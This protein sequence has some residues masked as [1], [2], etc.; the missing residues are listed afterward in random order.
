[1][2]IKNYFAQDA[3]GNIMP[4]AKC[5]LYLPGTTTLATGLVDGNGSPISNPFLASGMGQITF[6]APNGVYDLRVA[7]GSRD[8]TIKVQ[9]ADIVQAM[10]VMDSILGSHAEN[11]TTRNNGQPLEPG[12]ETWNSTDKQPYWWN[13]TAWVAL[14]S[15]TQQLEIALLLPS[16]PG[17]LGISRTP[18]NAA[19]GTSALALTGLYVS[20][21]EYKHLI[22]SKPD[23]DDWTTWNWAPAIEGA[24]NEQATGLRRVV[25]VL[26]AGVYQCGMVTIT[27]KHMWSLVGPGTLVKITANPVV[28][29]Y[30]CNQVFIHGDIKFDG[31]IV[32]DE[33]TNGSIIPG[34]GRTA[35][36]V[37]VYAQQCDDLK[38]FDLEFTG[39]ANDPISIRGQYVAGRGVPGS[40]G[41]TL[42]TP[43]K[44]VSIYRIKLHNF[45]NTA[46]YLAGVHGSYVA[47]IDIT[48]DDDFGYIRGNGIYYVDWCQ[49]SLCSNID[50]YRIGDNG[51][52]VGEV[53]NPIAQNKFIKLVDVKVDK[54]VYMGILVAGAEDVIVE[55]AVLK[56][57]MMQKALVPEAFLLPGNPG[58]LQVKGGNTSRNKRVKLL[59]CIVEDSYQRGIYVFDDASVL[60][61]HRTFGVEVVGNI[62]SRSIQENIYV[63]M[64]N[65][66][67]LENNEA[68]AGEKTGIFASGGHRLKGNKALGNKGH[69]ILSSQLLT[70]SGQ[71]QV[72]M[73]LLNESS[74]NNL[75]GMQFTGT[76]Q[77][78]VVATQNVCRENGLAGTTVAGRAGIRFNG[79][80]APIAQLNNAQDNQGAG[81]IFERCT[82]FLG[83]TNTTTNNG[84]STALEQK[85][86]AG[87]YVL[88]DLV[89]YRTGRLMSNYMYAGAN[90]QTGYA[91]EVDS[92]NGSTLICIGNMPDSHPLAPQNVARK[93]WAD[94]Y[95][96]V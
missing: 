95:N 66:V 48:N 38:L 58:A 43:S 3:Q 27:E 26:P 19:Q 20:V 78:R 74:G 5:Y 29:L 73:A 1:M 86:R 93:T 84:A 87:I 14:N 39:F 40:S 63:N 21:W 37:G 77:T 4:S 25:I 31:N 47:D 35:Y 22:T 72:V 92:T 17:K 68:Y 11:P 7:L 28:S 10:D 52:G 75:N 90:Q 91:A 42:Q 83:E 65:T 96:N 36:A 34:V 54:C 88:G 32:W 41:A 69:G 44:H 51:V 9:C 89:A 80:T 24:I 71:S 8:W 70:F 64:A 53:G 62:A 33:A 79:L 81:I 49:Y 57:C 23:P 94:I 85:E 18:I 13:G 6:G 30:R 56:K 45:R 46:I 61:E 16:G 15:S 76:A 82:Y 55:R 60:P 59:H 12:D 50:M 2:E 67:I